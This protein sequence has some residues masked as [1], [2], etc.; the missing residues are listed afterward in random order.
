[1]AK[2]FPTD[3]NET[4]D[5]YGRRRLMF[6]KANQFYADQII[7]KLK[8]GVGGRLRAETKYGA[9]TSSEKV[10][11]KLIASPTGF[12]Q[13]AAIMSGDPAFPKILK[14]GILDHLN[15]KV[16]RNGIVNPT[17]LKTFIAN[18]KEW[19]DNVPG[20]RKMLESPAH[21]TEQIAARRTQL[22][23]EVKAQS[24][25]A[26]GKIL[27]SEDPDKLIAHALTVPNGLAPVMAALKNKPE[28][29]RDLMHVVAGRLADAPD[30]A[31][32]LLDNAAQLK[33]LAD[34]VRP[35][36]WNRL[37]DLLDM[38]GIAKR[39]DVPT[40]IEAPKNVGVFEAATG[41]KLSQLWSGLFGR[42]RGSRETLAL[43]LAGRAMFKF[44]TAD[45]KKAQEAILFDPDI[46]ELMS[47]IKHKGYTPARANDLA[48]HFAGYGI[49]VIARG[50][51]AYNQPKPDDEEDQ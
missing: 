22:Q 46:T 36:Q 45:V 18:H 26:L 12:K 37:V 31:K 41:S 5:Y 48:N 20:L 38:R 13:A 49:R 2:K 23:A 15:N 27:G 11:L 51:E 32:A 35:G 39:V 21:A 6:K 8:Q 3:M 30:P 34:A 33:P 47:D 19:M 24:A 25:T 9:T 50:A 10:L 16:V 1:M 42:V 28:A 17:S 40:G 14:E 4:E 43:Q 7:P 29:L 44:N